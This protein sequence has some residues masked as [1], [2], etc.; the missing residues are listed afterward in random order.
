MLPVEADDKASAMCD[1]KLWPHPQSP[2]G[3]TVQW[4]KRP[5][6]RRRM[7]ATGV[8]SECLVSRRPITSISDVTNLAAEHAAGHV[9]EDLRI[10]RPHVR[11][12][13]G[14]APAVGL[15]A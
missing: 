15:P 7:H 11:A 5:R 8:V 4:T 6:V 12:T 3:A 1:R 14:G 10:H 2:C 9:A 13:A